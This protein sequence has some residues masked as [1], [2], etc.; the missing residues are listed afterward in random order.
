M[1]PESTTQPSL[2]DRIPT[3]YRELVDPDLLEEMWVLAVKTDPE[4]QRIQQQEREE[5]I[6]AF[7]QQYELQ[8]Q[9]KNRQIEDLYAKLDEATRS[10]FSEFQIQA[11]EFIREAIQSGDEFIARY[12][13]HLSK[14]ELYAL[15][16]LQNEWGTA[17]EEDRQF[18]VQFDQK[19]SHLQ[20]TLIHLQQRLALAFAKQASVAVQA[21]QTPQP[22]QIVVPES[23]TSEL[24]QEQKNSLDVKNISSVEAFA[25][26]TSLETKEEYTQSL[27]KAIEA[28]G[29]HKGIATLERE[30][31]PTIVISDIHARRD[32]LVNVLK[33]QIDG[34]SVHA[35]LKRGEIN[36]VC[37]GDG[38]HSESGK[39]WEVNLL[40][41]DIDGFLA[42]TTD[43]NVFDRVVEYKQALEAVAGKPLK[44]MTFVE[45]KQ[46]GNQA[47]AVA[48][49]QKILPILQAEFM[50]REMVKSL[51]A[52]KMV[53]DL[54]SAYPDSFH[55][56][57]GNHDDI[58]EKIKKYH[59]FA[60][61]S[62][63]VKEWVTTTYGDDF[64]QKYAQFEE[65]LPVMVRSKT[66]QIVVTHTVPD[67][68]LTQA[69][70]E[71]RSR[72]TNISLTWTDN[73]KDGSSQE[74]VDGTLANVN[75]GNAR[76]FIGHRD[77]PDEMGLAREQFGRVVQ[78]NNKNK[79]VIA[80]QRPGGSFDKDR[81]VVDVAA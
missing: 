35:K 66:G 50:K 1:Q 48:V 80:I 19:R 43:R 40:K 58:A 46:A 7:R 47:P 20:V 42:E 17:K 72:D 68:A 51:G 39:N 30:D 33:Y 71:G 79:Q 27:E 5:V 34:E 74:A 61:E 52:M 56:T 59:K 60:N 22:Q 13:K 12:A 32:F 15:H 64:L 62:Q 9:S 70:V 44:Q 3:R 73:T 78:I 29:R 81:D 63:Q 18:E 54:K 57:R 49:F 36:I 31:V 25:H 37:V 28:L 69:E 16:V 38:M 23:Q 77:V 14:E 4:K 26:N 8:E 11:G 76:W 55:Y 21:P 75:A 41:Y 53:M 45:I 65:A 67:K 24:K 2:L 6:R 10:R